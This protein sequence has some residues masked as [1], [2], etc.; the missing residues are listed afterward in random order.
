MQQDAYAA[1]ATMVVDITDGAEAK[2]FFV[3]SRFK[4]FLLFFLTIGC[5]QL[6]QFYKHWA[7]FKRATQQDVS[8]VWR[9]F[10]SVFF[11]HSLADEVEKRLRERSVPHAWSPT[12]AATGVVVLNIARVIVDRIGGNEPSFENAMI[13]LN[14]AALLP[15]SYFLWQIQYAANI[16]CGD[17]EGESNRRLTL[18]NWLWIVPLSAVWLLAAIGL[19]LPEA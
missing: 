7:A 17:A 16:A 3:V 14:L 6:V 4:F 5:Y 9:S 11:T 13:A 2:P 18:V 12:T 1:P 19:M 15:L 8:P 10:F